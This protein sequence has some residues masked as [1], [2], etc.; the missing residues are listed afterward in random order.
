MTSAVSVLPQQWL[1]RASVESFLTLKFVQKFP[2]KGSASI[3]VWR[4]GQCVMGVRLFCCWTPGGWTLCLALEGQAVSL[5][6]TIT[7]VMSLGMVVP[8][9]FD[10]VVFYILH[11]PQWAEIGRLQT[12]L[13][14]TSGP[15]PV[16][17]WSAS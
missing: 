1:G 10:C 3:E 13:Q 14:A 12:R 17:V 15:T 5:D 4:L 8:V 16:F 9:L 11:I 2:T 6:G 7:V